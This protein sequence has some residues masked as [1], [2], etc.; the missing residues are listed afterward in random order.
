MVRTQHLSWSGMFSCMPD[1][2]SVARQLNRDTLNSQIFEDVQKY[3]EWA[4]NRFKEKDAEIKEL[5]ARAA[6]CREQIVKLDDE[7]ITKNG[8]LLVAEMRAEA[9][10]ARQ[11]KTRPDQRIIQ[12]LE[13]RIEHTQDQLTDEVHRRQAAQ[14]ATCRLQKRK[15]DLLVTRNELQAWQDRTKAA[16]N[17]T[18]QARRRSVY[19]S[20]LTHELEL[21]R[22]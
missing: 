20:P 4:N 9:S 16:V 22:K 3:E 2:S 8:D 15:Q 18:G 5:K 14:D 17:Q 1:T 13:A 10:R 11:N 12:D 21:T 6:Q 7:L 19:C